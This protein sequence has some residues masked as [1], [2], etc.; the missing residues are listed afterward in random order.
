MAVMSPTL[1]QE[2]KQVRVDPR[3]V[4]CHLLVKPCSKVNA[5]FQ[6]RFVR[7]VGEKDPKIVVI[8]IGDAPI[9]DWEKRESGSLNIITL[10]KLE[11]L[12]DD[13]FLDQLRSATGIWIT[14]KTEKPLPKL[15]VDSRVIAL[16]EKQMASD[17]VLA[18]CG[19]A[20]TWMLEDFSTPS[21]QELLPHVQFNF[22]ESYI[23]LSKVELP[24]MN[25]T[26]AL[27]LVLQPNTSLE[28]AERGFTNIG[29]ESLVVQLPA[30]SGSDAQSITI[31]PGKSHDLVALARAA[32]ARQTN[33]SLPNKLAPPEV[34]NGSLVI[35]GGGGMPKEITEKFIELAGGPEGLIVVL[36]TA[37]PP[38]EVSFGEGN[39]FKRFG[40]TNVRVMPQYALDE[41]SSDEFAAVLREA[42]AVW[43][44]G[45]RQWRFV[46]AYENTRAIELFHAVLARG[47]VIG[48]SSAGAT[49]QGEY[50]SR[51]S[52]LGNFEMMS[53][54]YERGFSF[55]PG[56]VIDQ[57]F[58]NR[59]REPD[60]LKVIQRYPQLTGIGLDEATAIV[61]TNSS[62]QVLGRGEFHLLAAPADRAVTLDDYQRFKA[63]DV[64]DL[65]TR[66]LV[67]TSR[68]EEPPAKDAPARLSEPAAAN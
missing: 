32:L 27:R 44:G 29:I 17:C 34:K 2:A 8:A 5:E 24:A 21:H 59:K 38:E 42:K 47:G 26:K 60:L 50:L 46:D 16:L 10:E 49:I 7:A 11:S 65:V 39:F 53:E 63:G 55:L 64:V 56:T 40:A 67:R 3:G 62:A 58:A 22:V 4:G 52:P 66:K 45:G 30:G 23:D 35:V 48:G 28:I 12:D 18:I 68:K 14:A 54:G 31:E 33:A 19:D 41:V 1:G 25:P 43:F 15:P 51:G 9:G 61:V 37:V 36:P 57:H 6:A 20:A 13:L